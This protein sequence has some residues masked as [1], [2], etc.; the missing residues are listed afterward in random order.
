M[1]ISLARKLAIKIIEKEVS[2]NDVGDEVQKRIDKGA[3]RVVAHPNPQPNDVWLVAGRGLFHRA[4]PY[5]V[6]SSIER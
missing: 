3:A 4:S 5:R 6:P 2:K 1:R